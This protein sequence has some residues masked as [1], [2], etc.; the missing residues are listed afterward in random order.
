MKETKFRP[1]LASA[2]EDIT[3][4]TYPVLCTLKLDGLRCIVKSGIVYSRSMKPIPS[5][6]VQK[7]FGKV[8]YEGFDGELVYGDVFSHNVFTQS[9]SFCMSK[10]VPEGLQETEIFF[11]VFDLVDSGGHLERLKKLSER[12]IGEGVILHLPTQIETPEKLK[13]FQERILSL[14]GEGVMIRS[15]NGPYKQGRSTLKEG[16]LLKLKT[17][18]DSEATIIGFD[19]KMHNTNVAKVDE[20]GYTERSTSKE[21]M[22]GADTLGALV[23]H[24]DEWGEFRIGTGFDDD[25][26]REIW[27]NKDKYLGK[28]AKF[29]YFAVESG[30]KKPRFGVY[31]GIRSEIDT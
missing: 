10:K 20:L 2:C 28:L 5:E 21:G 26:R 24:S 30:Y 19:E 22:V 31:L 9:T 15:L 23:V 8:E 12:S 29:K 16:Y 17:F 13:E 6:V 1:I 7:K 18:E 25:L 11:Y 3:K 27:E 4:L 14:N